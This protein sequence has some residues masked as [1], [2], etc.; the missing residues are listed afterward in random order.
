MLIAGLALIVCFVLVED[1]MLVPLL[2]MTL[3]RNASPSVGVLPVAANFFALFG[4]TFFSRCT[5]STSVARLAS[6]LV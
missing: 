1:R 3:F 5:C 2:P 4:V 6:Q